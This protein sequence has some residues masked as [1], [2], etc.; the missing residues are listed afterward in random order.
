MEIEQLAEILQQKGRGRFSN[1]EKLA[2]A[3]NKAVRDS[4]RL[5]KVLE[6]SVDVVLATYSM[7]IKTIKGGRKLKN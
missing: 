6:G 7:M 2:K 3:I 5:G 4:Y 1:P